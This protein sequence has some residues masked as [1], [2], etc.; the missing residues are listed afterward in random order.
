VIPP[1]HY[2]SLGDNRY[3]SVDARYYGPIPRE[4]I[5]GRPMFIYLSIDFDDW[6]VRWGRIGRGIH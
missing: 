4:N 2:F 1:A 6:R 3:N 5:R